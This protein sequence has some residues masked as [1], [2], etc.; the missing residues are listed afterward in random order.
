[1]T[2]NNDS[3]ALWYDYETEETVRKPSSLGGNL[4]WISISLAIVSSGVL[5]FLLISM[6]EQW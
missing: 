3:D 5:D 1:M 2:Q 6:F 4:F